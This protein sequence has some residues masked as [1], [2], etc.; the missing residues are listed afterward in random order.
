MFDAGPGSSRT[1]T[2]HAVY[3]P[4]GMPFQM[5]VRIQYTNKEWRIKN[6]AEFPSNTFNRTSMRASYMIRFAYLLLL[7]SLLL[8]LYVEM[9]SLCLVKYTDEKEKNSHPYNTYLI[10]KKNQIDLLS[11]M[12]SL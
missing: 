12:A 11:F 9:R 3:Y 7:L 1:P 8:A 6:W 5:C 4:N 2:S 10:N